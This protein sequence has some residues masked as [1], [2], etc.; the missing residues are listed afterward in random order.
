MKRKHAYRVLCLVGMIL[1]CDGTDGEAMKQAPS[2]EQRT[3]AL[4]S[5]MTLEE[6]LEQMVGSTSLG[7]I[8]QVLSEHRP[9][10][11]ADNERLG[12][13]GLRFVDGPRGVTTCFPVAMARGAAWDVD[14]EERIGRAVGLEARAKGANILNAPCINLLR[15]PGWGRAQETYGEDP[16]QLGAMGVHFINGAQDHVMA[17]VKHYAL[18]S[19]EE[20]RFAIDIGADERTLREVYL[21]HFRKCVQEARTAA[22][23]CA[24]N[25]VNGHYCCENEHLLKE[26]LRDEWG[27]EGFV[28]TDWFLAAHSTVP[29]LRAGLDV[30][31][32]TPIFYGSRLRKELAAGTVTE[33]EIDEVLRRILRQK[34]RFGLLDGPLPDVRVDDEA[35][36]SLALEAARKGIV[37]LKNENDVLPLD[38][39]GV[40]GIAVIGRFADAARLGDRGSSN[41]IPPYVI[42]PYQGIADRAGS[43]V[44]VSF[45]DGSDLAAARELAGHADAVV[46]VAALTEQDEGEWIFAIGGDRESLALH[47]EDETLINELA[48][49]ADRCIVILEAGSAISMDAWLSNVE[50]VLMAWYPGQEGGNAIADVLF[51]TANPGGKLPITF[52]RSVG[53]I[54][55]FGTKQPSSSYGYDH[56]YTYFDRHGLEP[57]FPFGFG[58][59][60]TEYTYSNLSVSPPWTTPTGG[61]TVSLD[62]ANTGD[63]AGEETVQVYIGYEG[64]AVDRHVKELKAFGKVHLNPGERKTLALEVDARDLA[65]YDPD[66]SRWKVEDMAY[67]VY[68][69]ASSRDIR[70]TGTF[71]VESSP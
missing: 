1:S 35:H 12:I 16:F 27:F 31:M 29:S 26:I 49:V 52:P 8:L 17:D 15:H 58:L 25:Q 68:V 5:G 28:V 10:D 39:E 11:T 61:V 41:V 66:T 67:T 13:P 60:Y 56:G 54:Y 70:L 43:A 65:Y 6:K 34:I 48:A 47:A 36:G 2:I 22:V 51:G 64:S 37:L 23:M 42:T 57:L 18:N 14:L 24:Y 19:I 46:V 71:R 4:L 38:R 63:R 9:W 69:G 20:N 30:E 50:A 44:E 7:E 62:V 53:Q 55:P 33:D 45:N 59:S 32:P 21:P 3:E 40:E